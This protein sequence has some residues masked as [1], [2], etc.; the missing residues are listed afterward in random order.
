[1]FG[2]GESFDPDKGSYVSTGYML[3]FG[4]WNNSLSVICRQ[5]EHDDGRKAERRDIRVEPGRKYHFTITRRGG[6]IDW[7]IDGRP[8]L[9]WTDPEPLAGSGHEYMAFNNWESNVTFDN[10]TIRPAP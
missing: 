9:S 1:M 5:N 10:L 6:A 4:G 2:D 7:A 8:F 3:I